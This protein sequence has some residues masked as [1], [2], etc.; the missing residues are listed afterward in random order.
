MAGHY[1]EVGEIYAYQRPLVTDG[2]ELYLIFNYQDAPNDFIFPPDENSGWAMRRAV[3]EYIAKDPEFGNQYE[4]RI[5]RANGY[6]RDLHGDWV[7]E[8]W[9]K[10]IARQG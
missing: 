1:K 5:A 7:Y 2:F 6:W 3:K 10:P 8:L 4:Y 9:V